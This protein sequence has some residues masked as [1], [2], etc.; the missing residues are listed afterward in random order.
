MILSDT[1]LWLICI[2]FGLTI[3]LLLITYDMK[4]KLLNK[5]K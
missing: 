4:K 1:L 5:E 2:N 3:G